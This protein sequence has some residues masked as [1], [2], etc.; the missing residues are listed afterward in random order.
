MVVKCRKENAALK[1]CS[2]KWFSDEKFREECTQIYLERRAEFRRT[3]ITLKQKAAA[4]AADA[5]IVE[6]KQISLK[7]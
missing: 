4:A 1:E 7:E 2:A 6:W 3:G 5:N